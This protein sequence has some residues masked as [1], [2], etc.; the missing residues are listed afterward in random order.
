MRIISWNVRGLGNPRTLL[1]LEK[2]LHLHKPQL[3]FLCETKLMLVQV[4]EVCRKLELDN[5]FA[6]DRIGK[7]GS[8]A[9]I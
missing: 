2:I 3:L 8:L 9:L 7:I 4:K 1:A 5:S 6:V